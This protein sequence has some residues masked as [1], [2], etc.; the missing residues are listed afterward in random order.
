MSY[1]QIK[2]IIDIFF[3]AMLLIFILPML[4]VF[5]ILNFLILGSP[6]FFKQLRPGLNKKPFYLYKFRTMKNVYI[7][8]FDL[9]PDHERTTKYGNFLR[10]TSIDE[11]PSLFN[12][13]KGEL[14]FVG[15]RPLLIEYLPLYSDVHSRRHEI[16][17]G[18]TGWAA[19]NGRN[20]SSWEN[21]LNLD[22]WYV[23]NKSF[24]LDF[25]ILV[26]TLYKVLKREGINTKDGD[27]MPKLKKDYFK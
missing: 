14:S 20:M 1:T 4:M 10:K 2:G 15:P 3:A 6:I 19:V 27:L 12:I 16:K 23:K 5:S 25:K 7:N 21:K 17:P 24:F 22:I 11:L 18:L 13:L 9:K 8:N 26:L